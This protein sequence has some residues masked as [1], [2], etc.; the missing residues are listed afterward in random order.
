MNVDSI[1]T[2]ARRLANVNSTQWT[3]GDILE[4][5][6]IIYHDLCETIINEVSEDFFIKEFN[7]DTVI[8]QRAYDLQEATS[9]QTWHKKIKKVYVKFSANDTYYT[10]LK[11]VS[12]NWLRDDLDYYS[13]N[14]PTAEAFFFLKWNQ[15]VI[16]PSP[17]EEIINWL[18]V[19]SSITPIDLVAWW[20]EWTILIPRQFHNIIV[21]GMLQYIFAHLIKI[22]EKNDAINDY[23]RL[24]NDMVSE[25][26]DRV[27]APLLGELPNLEYLS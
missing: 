10:E 8:W 14:T 3:D 22:W 17:S 6:N 23:E 1:F 21:Q 5:L 13:D 12:F 18:I 20:A 16:F 19:E 24:K 7:T 9:I 15:I 4:D 2:R 25:L 26:S 27:I 11:E